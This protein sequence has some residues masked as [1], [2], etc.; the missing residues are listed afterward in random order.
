MVVV[1]GM[2]CTVSGLALA[3]VHAVTKEPI[4]YQQIKFVKEP[5]VK[6]VLEGYDNDP[7]KDRFSVPAGK[8]KKGRDIFKTVFP[9]KKSGEVVALALDASG[10]GFGGKI[11]VM[12]GFNPDGE[13]T[14]ISIMN[15]AETP[16]IGSRVTEEEF[17]EQFQGIAP[18]DVESVDGVS[19]ATYSTKGVV[20]AVKQAAKFFQERQE[21]LMA[22]AGK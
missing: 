1:L 15:H 12:V 10:K 22:Q 2:I 21:E 18:D 14:G 17:T 11:E 19:G 13:L 9:A 6:A 16:G 4:E 20:A 5:S 7:V 8:D 3:G